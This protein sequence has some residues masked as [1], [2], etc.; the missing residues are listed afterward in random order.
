MGPL[1]SFWP[2]QVKDPE[3]KIQRVYMERGRLDNR[4]GC[5]GGR[6]RVRG[7]RKDPE[8]SGETDVRAVRLS[9]S[10]NGSGRVVICCTSGHYVFIRSSF[11]SLY[12][13]PVPSV[14]KLSRG[15]PDLGPYPLRP[16]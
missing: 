12:L 10:F 14:G 9:R 16:P 1:F 5:V 4:D 13:S 7:S 3:F 6:V 2:R 11:P 8:V 15:P